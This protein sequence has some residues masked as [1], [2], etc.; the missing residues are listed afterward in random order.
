MDLRKKK[1]RK[2]QEDNKKES[3]KSEIIKIITIRFIE[4]VVTNRYNKCEYSTSAVY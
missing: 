3:L 4:T 2:K 1:K